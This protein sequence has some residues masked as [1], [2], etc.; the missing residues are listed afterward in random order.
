MYKEQSF[1]CLRCGYSST[2][3]H[4]EVDLFDDFGNKI[5]WRESC[6][7]CGFVKPLSSHEIDMIVAS[8]KG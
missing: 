2:L 8:A 3:V 6:P 5:R 1:K 4:K 7:E